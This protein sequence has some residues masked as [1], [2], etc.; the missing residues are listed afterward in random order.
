M[1]TRYRSN[2]EIFLSPDKE[3]VIVAPTAAMAD[4]VDDDSAL[5]R[6]GE[7]PGP[8]CCGVGKR[9]SLADLRRVPR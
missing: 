3:G 4:D 8:G 1:L 6:I 9:A 7:W 5:K 2:V